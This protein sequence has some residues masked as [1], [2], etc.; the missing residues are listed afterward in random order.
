M[1]ARNANGRMRDLLRNRLVLG[2]FGI[3]ASSG[4]AATTVPERWSGSWDDNL[5]LAHMADEAGIDFLLPIGR[6][7]GYGGET[8]FES[9]VLETVTW[10]TAILAST[11]RIAVFGTVH[12]PLVHPV[13]A[14]KQFT[15]A[16]LVGHGRFG[17]NVV[18]GWNAGEFEMFGV[19]LREHDRRYDYGR[20]WLDVVRS[21]WER[22]DEF[23]H[24]GEFFQ[25]RGVISDPKP[26]GGSRPI[27]MSAGGS[28]VGRTFAAENADFLFTFLR[29]FEQGRENV[30]ILRE[31][32]RAAGRSDIGIFANATVVCRPTSAEAHDYY[33]Y[34]AEEHGDWAAVERLIGL[35]TGNM[36]SAADYE[37]LKVRYAAGYGTF[38]LVGN[39]DEVAQTL[40]Q[41]SELGFTGMSL[42][43]VNFLAEFPYFRDEVLPR[44]ERMG[45]RQPQSIL[46]GRSA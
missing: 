36:S 10:A 25:L 45:L 16:D 30:G 19:E 12:A 34:Y 15:T 7:K 26:Y 33:R 41:I 8:Q 13:F 21:L 37:K 23:D 43:F 6:W 2:I 44:L 22:E 27:V 29:S 46:E 18:C 39:P 40:A 32:A 14:T 11:C 24:D 28:P 42:A 31:A 17:L 5:A 1:N 35:G 20:E 9:A 4:I 3:N 38:P